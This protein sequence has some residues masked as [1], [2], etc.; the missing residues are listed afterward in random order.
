MA[1]V[2]LDTA[3]DS[4]KLFP[5]L[6]LT[7]LAMELLKRNAGD[8]MRRRIQTAGRA[9]PLF[10]ALLGIVPQC[11]FSAA[12]ASLYAGRVITVGTLLAVFL[13]T[14][15][16]MLPILVSEA[17]PVATIARMLATKAVIAVISGFLADF[18]LRRARRLEAGEMRVE[19][20]TDDDC[21]E[22]DGIFVAALRHS[23]KIFAYIFLIS[24]AINAAIAWVGEDALQRVFSRVPGIGEVAAALLGLIPNCAASVALTQLYLDGIIGAG[25]VMAGL[26]VN[27]GVGVLVLFRLNHN[28]KENL[29]IVGMLLFFGI[30][31]GVALRLLGVTF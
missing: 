10:G 8:R 3:E 6:F 19:A 24:L 1:E 27:A 18:C 22:G 26:L 23:V 9:G 16:E 29:A 20:V 7:Y 17:V 31:W 2:L 30:F 28:L 11:G 13:S 25:A 5:F 15:D 21:H 4:V 12:A 14:S